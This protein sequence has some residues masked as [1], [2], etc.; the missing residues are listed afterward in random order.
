MRK[1][2]IFREGRQLHV[3]GSSMYLDQ[4]WVFYSLRGLLA[5]CL[6][7]MLVTSSLLLRTSGPAYRERHIFKVMSSSGF[8]GTLASKVFSSAR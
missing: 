7:I 5:V 6:E 4:E 8:E 1:C 3:L 2:R